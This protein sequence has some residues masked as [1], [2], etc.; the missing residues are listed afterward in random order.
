MLTFA[1]KNDSCE[2]VPRKLPTFI[3]WVHQDSTNHNIKQVA[4]KV[5]GY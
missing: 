4:A 3:L 2:D 1:N 5:N